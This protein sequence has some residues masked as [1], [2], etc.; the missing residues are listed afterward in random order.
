[1]KNTLR[2]IVMASAAVAAIAIGTVSASAESSVKVP[3]AF[4]VGNK[5]CPAG[6]Y[7][8]H[9]GFNHNLVTLS[10]RDSKVNFA[11]VL[12]PG[13]GNAE[14]AKVALKFDQIGDSQLLKT[15]QFG[16]QTTPKIDKGSKVLE[17]PISTTVQGQ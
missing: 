11:W 1:M 8:V 3:F 7:V 14:T 10:S 12:T 9:E 6:E 15:V 5:V 2:N 17:R 4:K 16:R 13:D